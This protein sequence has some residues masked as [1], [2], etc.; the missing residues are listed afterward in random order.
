MIEGIPGD[1][2]LPL[3]AFAGTAALSAL[4]G[5]EWGRRAIRVA[6][7]TRDAVDV[8]CDA[9]DDG[10]ITE[11]EVRAIVVAGTNWLEVVKAER[12]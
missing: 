8:I 4:A 10:K 6:Q 2:I 11:E 7:K 3:V 5:R 12:R 1:F 9:I